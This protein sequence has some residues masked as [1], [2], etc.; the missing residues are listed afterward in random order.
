[1][2]NRRFS[3]YLGDLSEVHLSVNLCVYLREERLPTREVWQAAIDAAGTRLNLD[4][5][6]TRS[7]DGFLPC[8]LDGADCGFEYSFHPLEGQDEEI[9]DRI[10]NCNR[11]VI[12]RFHSEMNDYKAAMYAAAALTEISGGTYYDPQ[13]ELIAT[14]N[15]VYELIR[16][17][18]ERERERGRIA[19]ARDAAITDNR[20]P[21]CGAPCPSYR[22]SCKACGKAVYG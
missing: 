21:H 22:K 15:G 5:F 1:M 9:R 14:G 13:G 3:S 6:D 16:Q 10:G 19:A 17:D 18:E 4:E 7:M 12:L 11:I 8:R 2:I 20:C